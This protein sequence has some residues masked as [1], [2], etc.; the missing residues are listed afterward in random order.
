MGVSCIIRLFLSK[1]AHKNTPRFFSSSI[2]FLDCNLSF[3]N[4]FKNVIVSDTLY[5][6][7]NTIKSLNFECGIRVFDV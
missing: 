5:M 7:R 2:L 3:W 6:V 4:R 1:I